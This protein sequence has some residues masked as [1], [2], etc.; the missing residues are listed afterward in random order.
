MPSNNDGTLEVLPDSTLVALNEDVEITLSDGNK[1]RLPKGTPA[2]LKQRTWVTIEQDG[3][4]LPPDFGPILIPGTM[5]TTRPPS[6]V[7]YSFYRSGQKVQLETNGGKL[8]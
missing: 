5:T 1:L 4:S 6:M 3:L 8:N 2:T 7:F